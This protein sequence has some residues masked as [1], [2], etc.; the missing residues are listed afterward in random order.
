MNLVVFG[1][2]ISSSWGNGHATIWRGLCRALA[3]RG[4]QVTFFERDV[5]YYKWHRDVHQPEGCELRLYE[6]WEDIRESAAEAT[7]LA[8][9]AIVTSYCPDALPASELAVGLSRFPVFYD[10]DTPVTLDRL[11]RGERVEYV[12][13]D[14]LGA[15]ALVLSFTGGRALDLLG[16]EL[17]AREVAPLYGSVDPEAHR[18]LATSGR[19]FDLSYLGTY[20]DDR[21]PALDELFLEPARRSPSRRFV[22][23][24]SMY[25]DRFPWQPNVYYQRHM[26]P[27]EHP[28]FYCSAS[29]TLNITR[30]P[31]ARMGYCPSGRLFEAAACGVPVISDDWEGLETFFEPDREI[32][33]VSTADDVLATLDLPEGTR[34]QIGNAARAR[35]LS[36][37]TADVRATE[38]EQLVAGK[39][40]HVGN[41]AG[42]RTGQPHAAARVLE[43]AA[44]RRQPV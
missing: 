40:L 10:L 31:M 15:F 23:A 33:V 39:G 21:Q 26:P 44:A 20:A 13:S 19:A 29:W 3:A 1:L 42:R 18:P 17:G 22:L 4:H 27:P 2:T 36:D 8:D 14:G 9:V 34:Q 24:G 38:L 7:R 41:C 16:D 12:P 30:G 28:A 11:A 35:A 6:T 25:P 43:G 5:P 37:H 32:V